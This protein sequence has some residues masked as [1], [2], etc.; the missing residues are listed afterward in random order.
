[1]SASHSPHSR[2]NLTSDHLISPEETFLKDMR[3]AA[4]AAVESEK[5]V[6]VGIKPDFPD[7]GFGY[8]RAGKKEMASDG[9]NIYQVLNF[10]EK[11]NRQRAK[12]FL[13]AGNSS[14]PTAKRIAR[15]S[16]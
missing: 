16:Q 10:T 15:S 3:L 5:I 7:T 9:K 13:A 1:M 2:I 6:T 11:P 4:E 12:K 8:I 14:F